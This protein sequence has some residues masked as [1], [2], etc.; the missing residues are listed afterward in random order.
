MM[1]G[2]FRDKIVNKIIES[3]DAAAVEAITGGDLD[4]KK[5]IEDKINA[6]PVQQLEDLILGFSKK[7]FRHITF[8][9]AILGGLIGL[10]QAALSMVLTQQ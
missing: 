4:I 3:L 10:V 5:K 6:M 8:F 9:G 2:G 7:Q 1:L